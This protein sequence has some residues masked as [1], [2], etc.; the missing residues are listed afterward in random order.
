LRNGKG[1]R[2]FGNIMTA[3]MTWKL[4]GL[5]ILEEVRKYL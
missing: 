4:R 3:V 1:M 2:M 5:N